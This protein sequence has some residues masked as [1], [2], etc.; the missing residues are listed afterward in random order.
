VTVSFGHFALRT[1]RLSSMADFYRAVLGARVVGGDARSV[2]LTYDGEHHR[3][4]LVDE[5]GSNVAHVAFAHASLGALVEAWAALA[6][7]GVHA[8]RAV[9]H[10]VTASLYYRDPD[11]NEIELYAN[12]DAP[13]LVP[14][15]RASWD[16]RSVAEARSAGAGEAQLRGLL[17]GVD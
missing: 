9:D 5:A 12:L 6:A 13:P 17:R 7:E 10:G 11:G 4:A 1:K 14:P 16:P 2:I 8:E 3:V 15:A